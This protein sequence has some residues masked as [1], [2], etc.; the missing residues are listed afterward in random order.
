MLDIFWYTIKL[1]EIKKI[2]LYWSVN[3]E[4]YCAHFMHIAKRFSFHIHVSLLFQIVF[5]FKLLQNIEQSALCY[6]VGPC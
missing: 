1:L 5:P 4:Q 6:M 3:G 2:I